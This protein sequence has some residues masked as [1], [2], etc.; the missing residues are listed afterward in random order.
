MKE[1]VIEKWNEIMELLHTEYGIK[2][3][4][5]NAWLKSLRCKDVV[6][7]KVLIVDDAENASAN[8]AFIRQRYG[9]YIKSAIMEVVNCDL[10]FE[11]V[12]DSPSSAKESIPETR[13]LVNNKSSVTLNP[14][15]T[16]DNF[17]VSGNNSMVYAASLKVAEA[18]GEIYNPLYIYGNPGLGK[19][20][21]MHSIAQYIIEN[22]GGLKV[23]YVTSD[24]FTNELIDSIRHGTI[25]P[26]DFRDK[27]RNIDVLLIDDIQFI[28]GKASTQEEFFNTFNYLYDAKKQIVISSDKP[29]KDF[30]DLEDRFRSR[31]ECG[32]IVDVQTPDFETKMAILKKKLDMRQQDSISNIVISDECLAYIANNINTNIR[33]LE[34]ALTKVLALAKLNHVNE[35]TM[36]QVEY[37]LRD[38]VFPNQ[39]KTITPEFIIEIVAEHSSIPVSEI[40]SVKRDSEITLARHISMYL[41]RKYTKCSFKEIAKIFDKDH[42]SVMHGVDKI[43]ERIKN[44]PDFASTMDT[45]VKKLNIDE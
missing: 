25:S 13:N 2:E 3:V 39:K 19:T 43:E 14:D 20:H 18:P 42:T 32:L 38:M 21:L 37:A 45:I 40:L 44:E 10:D 34:G 29:P 22:S 12:S 33:S 5:Y 23:M 11:I 31:F 7:N 17:V 1:L 41:C 4:S 6:D 30:N 26:A 24:S 15:Y 28:I 9:N 8:A 27:Y 36:S 16:F 35:V